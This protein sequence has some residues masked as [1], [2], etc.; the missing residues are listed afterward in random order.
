LVLAAFALPPAVWGTTVKLEARFLPE[1]QV[2][3]GSMW[4]TWDS[5]L[6]V[7]HFALLANL[8][9]EENPYLSGRARDEQYVDGFD[10]SWT[11]VEQVVWAGP[12]GEEEMPFELLPAPPT[13]QTY[14]LEEVL[15]LVEL[16]GEEGQLRIDFRTRFPH[17]RAGAPGRLFDF[18]TWRFGWHHHCPPARGLLALDTARLHL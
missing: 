15:L 3:S 6:E 8:G 17:V 11:V 5:P 4:V 12:T 1:E 2:I 7:A 14:S 9:K 13:L 16:P 10:P 18:Y